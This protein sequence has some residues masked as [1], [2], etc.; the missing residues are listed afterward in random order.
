MSLQ[1]HQIKTKTV[2]WSIMKAQE[3]SLS[4]EGCFPF[5]AAAT[6]LS[7]LG[8]ANAVSLN[9]SSKVPSTNTVTAAIMF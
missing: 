6:L 5:Q 7:I 4:T 3:G 9:G 8:K 2:M 1:K